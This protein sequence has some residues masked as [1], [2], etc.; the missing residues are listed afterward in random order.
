MLKFYG[1]SQMLD[2]IFDKEA[3][4]NQEIQLLARCVDFYGVEKYRIYVDAVIDRA[5]LQCEHSLTMMLA[6]VEFLVDKHID[7]ICDENSVYRLRLL[8][9]KY[10]EVDYQKL[11][12][13]LSAAYRCLH[14]VAEVMKE[15]KLADDYIVDY[16]LGNEFVNR[17]AKS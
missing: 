2:K 16:W 3:N 4:V 7:E 9:E 8:L 15:K 14:K 11:N 6:F 10:I 12:L 5:L 17:F 13:V 1:S